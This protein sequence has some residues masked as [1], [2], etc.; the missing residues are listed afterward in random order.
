MS[1][2]IREC[3]LCGRSAEILN[4]CTCQTI[5]STKKQELE[6][7]IWSD[8]RRKLSNL[9]WANKFIAPVIAQSFK[10]DHWL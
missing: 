2:E 1:G 3:L 4:F 5:A 7:V 6:M 8:T 10:E 9:F